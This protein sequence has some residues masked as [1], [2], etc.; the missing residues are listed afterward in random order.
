MLESEAANA[1]M[2]VRSKKKS[3]VW[4]PVVRIVTT[5]HPLNSATVCT[6]VTILAN[7]QTS[8]KPALKSIDLWN[9]LLSFNQ[10]IVKYFWTWTTAASN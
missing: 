4:T 10:N 5:G 1:W 6:L 7:Y 2:P 8:D 9:K 3:T